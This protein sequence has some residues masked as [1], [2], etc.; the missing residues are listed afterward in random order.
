MVGKINR[1][2]KFNCPSQVRSI[3]LL[4]S[5]PSFPSLSSLSSLFFLQTNPPNP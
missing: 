4:P 5:L 2:S 3:P 1:G